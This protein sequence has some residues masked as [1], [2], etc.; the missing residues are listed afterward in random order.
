MPPGDIDDRERPFRLDEG[1]DGIVRLV[2][3]RD[4]RITGDMAKH[5]MIAVDDLNG[6]RRRPLLVY[7]ARTNAL[8]RKA[9]EHFAEKCSTSA[10]ALLGETPVDRLLATFI[11]G[12]GRA[13]APT[14]YFTEESEAIAWLLQA[15]PPP[16]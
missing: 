5:A 4:L 6:S 11:L 13:P 1:Q 15:A 14:R 7:M 16:S 9:R 3:E 2:W 12:H 10:I 8:E